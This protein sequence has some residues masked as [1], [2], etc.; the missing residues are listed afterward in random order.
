MFLLY[1]II[2]LSDIISI[3]KVFAEKK[4][5]F[6]GKGFSSKI[7]RRKGISENHFNIS[8]SLISK[9]NKHIQSTH[10]ASRNL[11]PATF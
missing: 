8:Y 7:Q 10:P 3:M 5:F 2:P 1:I 9:H 6:Q 4:I 11:N